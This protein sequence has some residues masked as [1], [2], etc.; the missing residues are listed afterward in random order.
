MFNSTLGEIAIYLPAFPGGSLTT[1]ILNRT[2]RL[3]PH[4]VM[5]TRPSGQLFPRGT[6]GQMC[7]VP[8]SEALHA[9]AGKDSSSP[10]SSAPIHIHCLSFLPSGMIKTLQLKVTLEGKSSLDLYFQ[11]IVHH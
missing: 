9:H 7:P 4:P 5:L 6:L 3:S 8:L 1:L 2:S 10:L 11:V